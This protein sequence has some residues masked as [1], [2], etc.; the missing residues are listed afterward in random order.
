[1]DSARKLIAINIYCQPY[2]QR[3]TQRQSSPYGRVGQLAPMYLPPGRANE[4]RCS[5]R[6]RWRRLED[7]ACV[8]KR[9]R[10]EKGPIGNISAGPLAQVKCPKS[11]PNPGILAR[12]LARPVTSA[13][14]SASR[15]PL[16]PHLPI[17]GSPTAIAAC[18][19]APAP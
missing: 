11:P 19:A 12:S 5:G 10:E 16:L 17:H 3:H 9:L 8:R 15:C 7:E 2:T 1:M 14:Q 6:R 13:P 18:R 4:R